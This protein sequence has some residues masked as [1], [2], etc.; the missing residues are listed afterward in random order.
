MLENILE[1]IETLPPLPQTI[2]EI[3]TFRKQNNQEA[4]ELV[5][6]VEKDPLCVAT[7]LKIS[8]SSLFGFNS[9]IETVKR[10]INLLG[11]N[12]TIYVAIKEAIDSVL[13]IDLHPYGINCE[14]FTKITH[15]SLRFVD[16]WITKMDRSF[17]DEVILACL[18]HETGKFLLSETIINRGLLEEFRKKIDA[19]ID[20]TTIENELVEITTHKVTAEI[21]RYWKFNNNL[22]E[23]IEFVD[24]VNA[25]SKDNR[26]KCQILDIVRTLFDLRNPLSEES[27][28]KALQKAKEYNF[29]LEYLNYAIKSTNLLED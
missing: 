23:I 26:E 8:N 12:F 21:F 3:E 1:K 15:S 2:L 28:Q 4:D 17:K 27:K 16:L 18:L 22:I 13:K 10:V 19:G 20:I 11:I 25:C 14:N 5:K 9:K 6:I 7:L 24:D 29:D